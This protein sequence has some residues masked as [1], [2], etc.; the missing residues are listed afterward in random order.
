MQTVRNLLLVAAAATAVACGDGYGTNPDVP[1]PA[2]IV[3]GNGDVTGAV[4][5]FRAALG[6]PVN[7]GAAGSQ[8]AGRREISWDGVPADLT[9]NEAFPGDFFNTRAPRGV[10]FSTPGSGFRISDNNVADLDPSFAQEFAFFSPRKTFL[11]AGS[12]VMDAEFRVPAGSDPAAV[13]GFG[14]VFA[15]VDRANSATLEF[16][17]REGSLGRFEAPVR[18]AA[19]AL[20]FLGVTFDEKIVTRVRITSGRAP[21]AAGGRDISAGGSSDLVI[22]DD[23]LFDEPQ[24]VR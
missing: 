5:E 19:G 1:T 20:S 11:A 8:P 7:G 16:F 21:V 4:A 3:T 18:S 14:V 6:D 2:R 9:N 12:N 13:R 24:P 10:V 23:F 17:G 15:D 22:M